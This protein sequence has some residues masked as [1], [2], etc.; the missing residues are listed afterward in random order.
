MV[1]FQGAG[2]VEPPH[3][4]F[5]G[6][7][8]FGMQAEDVGA[9]DDLL[10]AIRGQPVERLVQ[11]HHQPMQAVGAALGDAGQLGDPRDFDF[12]G[13]LEQAGGAD[14]GEPRVHGFAL[15]RLAGG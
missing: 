10:G 15:G 2:L 6:G 14:R 1:E 11:I 9:A 7:A 13:G 8:V 5:H 3:E 4:T 12:V